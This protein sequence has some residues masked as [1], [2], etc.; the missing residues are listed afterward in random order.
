MI[1]IQTNGLYICMLFYIFS[2]CHNGWSQTRCLFTYGITMVSWRYMKQTIVA[3][4]SN[5][6]KLRGKLWIFL[7]KVYNSTCARNLWLSPTKMELKTIYEDNRV[8]FNWKDDIDIQKIHLCEN[9]AS[10]FMKF[11]PRRTF[12]KK[13]HKFGLRHLND[14]SYMRGRNRICDEQYCIKEYKMLYSFSFTRF[15]VLKGFS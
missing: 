8:L 6:I 14:V 2:Q 11:L 13:I 9:M 7:A 10:L 3:T 4:S 1:Q 5:H 15:F 12:E